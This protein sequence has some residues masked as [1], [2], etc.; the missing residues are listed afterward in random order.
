MAR[1]MC[2]SFEDFGWCG[3]APPE[4]EFESSDGT[5]LG[6]GSVQPLSKG[7]TTKASDSGLADL[8]E[9]ELLGAG[10]LDHAAA[11]ASA[12]CA[13]TCCRCA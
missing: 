12:R 7:T 9:L 1:G 3:P 8:Y 6:G 2:Q 5:P 11:R 13:I 4:F 10:Q